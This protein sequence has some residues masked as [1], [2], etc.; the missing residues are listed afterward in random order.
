MG[1]FLAVCGWLAWQTGRGLHRLPLPASVTARQAASAVGVVLLALS[2]VPL[3]VPLFDAQPEAITV[4]QVM[5]G[6]VA[7]PGTWV[8][9]QG[10][11]VELEESPVEEPGRYGILAD[12][13]NPLRSIVVEGNLDAAI[14]SQSN[15]TGHLAEAVVT[16]DV[17][18]LPIEA[19]VAGTPPEVV[20]DRIV[21]LDPEPRPMRASLWVF[22]LIPLLLGGIMLLGAR[23]GYPIFRETYEV[24]V[25]VTPLGAGERLPAAFG[26]RV[27]THEFPLDDPGAALL[28]VR[29]GPK[30]NVLTVQPLVDEGP[31]P[32]GVPIGGGWT[33]GRTGYVYTVSE[34]VPALAIR[35]EEVDATFLFAN[36]R[37]RDRIAALVAVSR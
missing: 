31:P 8:R 2:V 20:T 4:Q 32:Q 16:V 18:E 5:D 7:E 11:T 17:E 35:S 33:S 19:T 22:S 34:S 12:A 26:G 14:A 29:R 1:R 28:I 24:D 9:L 21:E 6:A 15:V 23:I 27:G 3:I 25:L 10:T 30:G 36:T 13:F 37:E